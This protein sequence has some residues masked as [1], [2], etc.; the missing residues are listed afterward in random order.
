MRH[1]IASQGSPIAEPR[2]I[3][4]LASP[5]RQD[6]LDAV[7]AI[8][9]CTV[10]EL[11]AALGKPPDAMYYH[12]RRLLAVRLLV[13]VASNGDERPDLRLDVAE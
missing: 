11:A 1:A 2:Q 4:A 10:A 3:R 7:V 8:G 12:I 13:E 5:V 6:I 9:P